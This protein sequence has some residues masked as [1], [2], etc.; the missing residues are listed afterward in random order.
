MPSEP[1]VLVLDQGTTST[2]ATVVG[3]E[4]TPGP[5]ARRRLPQS[6][7]ASGRV[8]HDPG[9]I[10]S[11]ALAVLQEAVERHGGPESVTALGITNQRETT[12]VWE[13]ATGRPVHP[14]IVWQDRR[15]AER[16]ARLREE[17]AEELVRDRTGLVLDPYFS[18]TKLGWILDHVDG[19]RAAAERGELAF[20]T[21]DSWLLW[22]LTGGAVH[23]TDATNASRT[24][25][26]DIHRQRWDPELLELFDVPPALLPEVRDTAGDFGVTDARAA[27][28]ELPVT[29]LVGDQQAAA[30]GQ[31]AHEPG[32]VK[33]TYGTGAFLLE[34]TG[35]EAIR[36]EHRLL[37]TVAWRLAGRTT[38]AL[39]GSIFS[40]GSAVQWMHEELEFLDHPAESAAMARS[41]EGTSG[42]YL[43]PAFTGLGAPHWDADA[44]GALLGL[45][46][47]SGP[48]EVVRAGLESIAYQTRDLLEAMAADG[49]RLP[50]ALRVDG[51]LSSN[52]WAMEFL[53]DM[54][55]VPVQRPEVTETTALGAGFLAGLEA[56]VFADLDDVAGRWREERSWRPDMEPGRRERLYRGWREAVARVLSP[57][58]PASGPSGEDDR[59]SR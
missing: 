14:A 8:E 53:S 33:A 21:V 29:A 38:Y 39:E 54:L 13:R 23:A 32:T 55:D 52:D 56:G 34:N 17:G 2:R 7:P 48:E 12:V 40:A 6:Y 15:T 10:W 25:L 51:G 26:F 47:D 30:F 27:G 45:G 4:G 18:A 35:T 11:D 42:V 28:V 16:C 46:R 58:P 5:F 44:R 59:G 3:P 24:A 1:G 37:T 49:A 50:H 43:V 19:A 36:S 9:R 57:P 20:G 22:K 41:V 31:A